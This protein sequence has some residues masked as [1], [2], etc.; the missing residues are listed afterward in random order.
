MDDAHSGAFAGGL[1][2]NAV[3]SRFPDEIFGEVIQHLTFRDMFRFVQMAA[4]AERVVLTSLLQS[5]DG[6]LK[7]HSRAALWVFNEFGG[8]IFRFRIPN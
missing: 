7:G 8:F 6:L 4:I 3:S 5:H 1:Y 2:R